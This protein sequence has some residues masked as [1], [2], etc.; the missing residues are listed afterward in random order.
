MNISTMTSEQLRSAA[1]AD[2]NPDSAYY[3]ECC[4]RQERYWAMFESKNT[5]PDD[6][7]NIEKIDYIYFRNALEIRIKKYEDEIIESNKKLQ[8]L[9]DEFLTTKGKAKQ[10]SIIQKIK[11]IMTVIEGHEKFLALVK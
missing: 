8:L 11:P 3:W 10:K 1:L 9:R 6:A 7:T 5:L 2:K 4:K